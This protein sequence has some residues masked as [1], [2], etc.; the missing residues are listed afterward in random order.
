LAIA[1]LGAIRQRDSFVKEIELPQHPR[2]NYVFVVESHAV[3]ART[4]DEA[5]VTKTDI[6]HKSGKAEVSMLAFSD[7]PVF[8]LFE[9]LPSTASG[10][11]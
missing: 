3:R 4:A 11:L 7:V 5:A 8:R 6:T 10:V 9:G 2:G 1:Q